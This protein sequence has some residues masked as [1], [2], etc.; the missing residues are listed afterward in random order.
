[1]APMAYVR[2]FLSNQAMR[3]RVPGVMRGLRSVTRGV[4]Q[5]GVLSPV[6]ISVTVTSLPAAGAVGSIPAF[7]IDMAVNADYVALREM[8]WS[9]RWRK[10]VRKL[11]W[12]LDNIV[13]RLYRL[14]LAM[15]PKKPQTLFKAPR[16]EDKST[17][18]GTAVKV[19]VQVTREKTK[20][21]RSLEGTTWGTLQE[22]LLQMRQCLIVSHPT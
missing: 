16:L 7:P 19:E 17:S 4:Q 12:S 3:V 13:R 14:G 11:Q 18:W 9:C 15:L 10:M 5:G 22:M 2:A 8:A 1:M 21:L 6:L 20:V